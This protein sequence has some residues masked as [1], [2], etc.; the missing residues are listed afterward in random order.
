MS[1]ARGIV[2]NHINCRLHPVASLGSIWRSG[3]TWCHSLL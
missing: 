2:I 3:C 1:D